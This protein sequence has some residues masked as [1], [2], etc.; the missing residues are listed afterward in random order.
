MNKVICICGKICSGKTC[1]AKQIA[2]KNNA[3]ILSTDEATYDLID[4]MQGEFY[5]AFAKRVNN[6][7]KKKAVEIVN[8]GADVILDWGF[9]TMRER[10]ETSEYFHSKGVL[11]EWIYI[12][13]DD[14]MW[15]NNIAERNRQV[16]K[17]CGQSDFYV[18]DGLLKKLLSQFEEPRKDEIDVWYKPQT[19]KK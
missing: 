18:D 17:G 5:D 7:L 9:W 2:E 16:E 15:F 13:V 8:A 4:N 19:A 12:D 3:V 11:Y 10:K 6:Y 14:K 1:Y